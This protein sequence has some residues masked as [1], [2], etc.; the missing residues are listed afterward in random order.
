MSKNRQLRQK[1]FLLQ[2]QKTPQKTQQNHP[3]LP[4][5]TIQ[6]NRYFHHVQN[7]I[8]SRVKIQGKT[9]L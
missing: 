9:E 6:A 5:K 8:S 1:P 2:T 3:V 7:R 4:Q